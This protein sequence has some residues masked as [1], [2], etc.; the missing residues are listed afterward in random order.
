[1]LIQT[2]VENASSAAEL[3]NRILELP[4]GYNTR[5]GE[6]GQ[7]LSGGERLRVAIARIFLRRPKI[8]AFDEAN[9]L[10]PITARK[11]QVKLLAL[12]KGCTKIVVSHQLSTVSGA[13][14]IICVE[15]G[16]IVEQGTHAEL[17]SLNGIYREMWEKQKR[18]K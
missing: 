7:R 10:D 1:L 5:V 18:E 6:R 17:I 14:L 4:D 11:I 3:H 9:A 16:K 2:E 15:G 8:L 12:F 13:N